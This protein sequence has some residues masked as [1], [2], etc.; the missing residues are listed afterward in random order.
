M[1]DP[2]TGYHC[3][4]VVSVQ[5]TFGKD[6]GLVPRSRDGTKPLVRVCSMYAGH[7]G[8]ARYVVAF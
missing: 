1:E 5:F 8:G 7:G 3:T 2:E 4:I 6:S